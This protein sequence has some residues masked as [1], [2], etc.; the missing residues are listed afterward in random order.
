MTDH[1]HFASESSTS[2]P[3]THL[4]M[5]DDELY[6]GPQ[7]TDRDIDG[8]ELSEAARSLGISHDEIWRRIRNGKLVARTLRGKVFVY[9]DMSNIFAE[10]GL[11]PPPKTLTSQ[12]AASISALNY[13]A[14]PLPV[15]IDSQDR[16]HSQ[17]LALLIDHLSLAKDE[18]REILKLTQD[19]MNR[20]S[21]MTDAIIE[22]KDAM[23]AAKDDQ[24][25]SLQETLL[26]RSEELVKILKEKEDLETLTQTLLS[27]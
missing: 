7:T 3:G 9:T 13:Q 22:M 1:E 15:V 6:V 5:R 26:S 19:S 18:N 2:A 27:K 4:L 11:P 14:T 16:I 12:P 24:V 17:E 10:E 8:L 20:L 25:K 23:I 21:Q